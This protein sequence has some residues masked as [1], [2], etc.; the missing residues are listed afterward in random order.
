MSNQSVRR[1]V[2]G[3]SEPLSARASRFAKSHANLASASPPSP[4]GF[5]EPKGSASTVSIGPTAP[6][7]HTAA[8]A[9]MLPWR[10]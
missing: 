3:P 1:S 10:I 8:V 9:P 7:P 2:V 4:S 6:L 5:T